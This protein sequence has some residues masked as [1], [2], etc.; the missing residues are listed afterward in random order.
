MSGGVAYSNIVVPVTGISSITFWPLTSVLIFDP[1]EIY[2]P[3]QLICIYT[4]TVCEVIID[5]YVTML[6]I[7]S[8]L[9]ISIYVHVSTTSLII[10]SV[11]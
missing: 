6:T 1:W 2:I 8:P 5:H 4:L 3:E 11:S 10:S 9:P 7:S